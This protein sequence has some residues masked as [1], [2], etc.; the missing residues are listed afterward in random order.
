MTIWK[1]N[2]LYA[3]ANADEVIDTLPEIVPI[4]KGSSINELFT[5]DA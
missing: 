4:V 2:E 5:N 3:E 1:K